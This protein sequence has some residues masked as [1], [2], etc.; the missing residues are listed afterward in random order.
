MTA[1]MAEKPCRAPIQ[2]EADNGLKNDAYTVAMA[3]TSEPH[4]AT[5]QFFINVKKNDFLNHTARTEKGWGYTVF[6]KVVQGHGVVN[7]IKGV[8]TGNRKGHDDVPVED[9]ILLRASVLEG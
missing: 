9:V 2:N 3:R 6:G 8:A 1:D 4:S 5:A 7:K